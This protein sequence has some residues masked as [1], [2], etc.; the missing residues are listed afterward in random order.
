MSDS[1]GQVQFGAFI[2]QSVGFVAALIASVPVFADYLNI[3]NSTPPE[4]SKPKL[5]P[6]LVTV[7]A[8]TLFLFLFWIRDRLVDVKA[9]LGGLASI[10]IGGVILV[11]TTFPYVQGNAPLAAFT[12]VVGLVAFLGGISLVFIFGFMKTQQR[13][14]ELAEIAPRLEPN[15]WQ[16]LK[17]FAG[18]LISIRQDISKRP[19]H[20]LSKRALERSSGNLVSEYNDMLNKLK[21]GT[22]EIRGP[23]MIEIY[24]H[25]TEGVQEKFRALSCNDLDYWAS[26]ERAPT[27]YLEINGQLIQRNLHVE[28]VFIISQIATLSESH[29]QAISKQINLKIRV[30]IASLKDCLEIENDYRELDF[31]LFDTFAVSFWKFAPDRVFKIS[32]APDECRKRVE[33]YQRVVGVCVQVPG[34]TGGDPTIFE[35]EGEL[36]AWRDGLP[37]AAAAAAGV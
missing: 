27:R 14:D 25:F 6:I 28:R 1:S 30:R 7:L 2:K 33:M 37:R 16:A 9:G 36:R 17:A 5:L 4:P 29:L 22:L 20:P 19:I 18:A 12:Y 31:G 21:Q 26:S 3:I 32:T 13:Q 35:T 15:E 23:A 10:A 8:G 34:K 11:L 24:S